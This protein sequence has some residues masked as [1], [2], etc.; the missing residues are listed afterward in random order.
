MTLEVARNVVS[1]SHVSFYR[2]NKSN[3]RG[4]MVKGLL[5]MIQILDAVQLLFHSIW[6]LDNEQCN[7]CGCAARASINDT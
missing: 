6:S 7:V 2:K 5:S 3:Y 1:H 4:R